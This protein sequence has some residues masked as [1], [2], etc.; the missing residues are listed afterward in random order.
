MNFSEADSE[1][2]YTLSARGVTQHRGGSI[3]EFATLDQWERELSLFNALRRLAVFRQFRS[4]KHIRWAELV[5]P[6][7]PNC[8][9]RLI[10]LGQLCLSGRQNGV[11]HGGSPL[12]TSSEELLVSLAK[13]LRDTSVGHTTLC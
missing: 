7:L 10:S 4:W 3:S 1:E 2:L 6:L 12:K 9:S 5:E 8:H 13:K 11:S